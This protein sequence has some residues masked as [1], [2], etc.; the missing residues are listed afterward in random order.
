MDFHQLRDQM[1]RT[2]I[3]SRDVKDPR[4]LDAFKNVPRHVFVPEKAREFSYQDRPLPIGEGQTISQP[5]IVALMTELLD[6]QPGIKVLEI[7]TGSGYQAAVLAY[8]G[9]QVYSLEVKEELAQ[10]AK[11]ILDSLGY[12][13]KVKVADGSLGWGE[14]APYDRII[15]TAA[16]PGISPC[17]QEQLRVGGKM[18]IPLGSSFQQDLTLVEKNSQGKVERNTVCGCIFVPLVGEYGFK[19]KDD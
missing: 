2:Q 7:G 18:V 1:V 19:T 17:W 13:V 5:Y 11:Q 15:V 10:R 4:V 12:E 16:S 14:N 9:A 6:V 8:L 3:L